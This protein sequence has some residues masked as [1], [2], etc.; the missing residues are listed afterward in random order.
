MCF[1]LV[2]YQLLL[3]PCY[4]WMIHRKRITQPNRNFW[5][6][7]WLVIT[8]RPDVSGSKNKKNSPLTGNK[9]L[10]KHNC[11]TMIYIEIVSLF[12]I[13]RRTSWGIWLELSSYVY[14]SG[15]FSES[16]VFVG[17]TLMLKETYFLILLSSVWGSNF[18]PH[19]NPYKG[20]FI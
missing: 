20:I 2:V 9:Y 14:Q 17:E 10:L 6:S 19:L 3:Y 1:R 18:L 11:V 16:T 15:N 12:C 13:W 4:V 5:R 7:V 8:S